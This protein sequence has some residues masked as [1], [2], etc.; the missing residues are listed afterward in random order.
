M[1]IDWTPLI[2]PIKLQNLVVE[3]TGR[4]HSIGR[5]A[6]L[7]HPPALLLGDDDALLHLVEVGDADRGVVPLLKHLPEL[8]ELQLGSGNLAQERHDLGSQDHWI[9][10]VIVARGKDESVR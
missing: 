4:R 8:E 9:L 2:S 1:I 5:P 3:S 7:H 10:R 6:E